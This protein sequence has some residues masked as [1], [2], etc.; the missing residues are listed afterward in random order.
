[1]GSY[2]FNLNSSVI[3]ASEGSVKLL[4]D[5]YYRA[6]YKVPNACIFTF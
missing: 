4:Q 1:M 6:Q 5:L 2:L 3:F